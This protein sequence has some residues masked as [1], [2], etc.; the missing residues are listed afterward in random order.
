MVTAM[1]SK[2]RFDDGRYA[3]AGTGEKG[4]LGM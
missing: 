3:R 1:R 4:A 2:D